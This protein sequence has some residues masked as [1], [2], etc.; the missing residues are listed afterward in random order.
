MKAVFS[1]LRTV[2]IFLILL[3]QIVFIGCVYIPLSYYW[4]IMK[5]KELFFLANERTNEIIFFIEKQRR[6]VVEL[7]RSEYMQQLI[8][9]AGGQSEITA[10]QV[11][12][13]QSFVRGYQ[14]SFGYKQIFLIDQTGK[15][16]FSTLEG[17]V[18]RNITEEYRDSSITKSFELIR[19]TFTSEISQLMYDPLVK[20]EAL[21]M[22]MPVFFEEKLIGFLVAQLDSEQIQ[23]VIN[24]FTGLGEKG[25]FLIAERL[26]DKLSFVLPPR[27]SPE[28][29]FARKEISND[30]ELPIEKAASGFEGFGI[31]RDYRGII[32][33]SAWYFI[34][35][36][37]W[38]L[39][40]K[41]D[42]DSVMFYIYLLRYLIYLL[43]LCALVLA[44][45]LLSQFLYGKSAVVSKK[46]LEDKPKNK[47]VKKG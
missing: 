3:L 9:F 12:K 11:K 15:F 22:T 2:R 13:M 40:A 35:Q 5:Q 14:E 39:V 30:L 17:L 28:L 16:I 10:L 38:G 21:F 23:D 32:T 27:I 1:S 45:F 37:N 26:G 36:V 4:P 42:L 19:M 6:Y 20:Q 41:I 7:A 46:S 25:E 29:M 18:G 44:G 34:P 24:K 47:R 31:S 33:A 43:M 8:A